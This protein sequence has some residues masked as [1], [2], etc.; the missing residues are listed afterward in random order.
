MQ[1]VL[2]TGG[3]G[4]IGKEIVKQLLQQGF[5]VNILD[6]SKLDI[7][8]VQLFRGSV[9]EPEL[10]SKAMSGCDYVIHLAAIL[11]VSKSAY[12]PV[13]CLDV[14]ILGTRNVLKCAVIHQ[15][16]K[17]LFPSSSEVYGEPLKVPITE[18]SLLQPKSEYGVSKSVGE[19]YL[20]AFKKQHGL[21]YTIV[22]F[23]NVYG[24]EQRHSWVM[25][26]FINDA[27]LGR[28]LKVF[29]EGNQVRAFCHVQDAARGTIT[30]LLHPDADNQIFNI[31]NDAE[32]ITMKELAGKILQEAGREDAPLM[33]PLEHSDRTK[34]REIFVRYPS[35]EKA[36][37]ILQFQPNITLNKGIKSLLEHKKIH[38]EQTKW[39]VQE[40]EKYE[41]MVHKA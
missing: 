3:S 17:V 13:E 36:R 33:I 21:N 9:L 26:K 25:A 27:V 7:E 19:E 39:E 24:E 41:Q 4:F 32:P 37:K 18:D 1:K 20:K 8:G 14:N 28:P 5:A 6:S 30:A 35:I 15:I 29:G 38:L 12:E 23:F 11:G 16:K 10:I 31:G 2:V 40:A 22:R 34:A